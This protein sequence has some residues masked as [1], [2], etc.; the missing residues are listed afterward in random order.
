MEPQDFH[1]DLPEALIAQQPLAERT[2]SRLLCVDGD[3]CE[4]RRFSD[5]PDLLR[6]GDLL[7]MN[8]TRVIPARL[9]GRKSSGGKIELLL[10]RILEP[11]LALGDI[12]SRDCDPGQRPRPGFRTTSPRLATSCCATRHGAMAR[13]LGAL[14]FGTT[15]TS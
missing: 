10:E 7:V 3:A 4:D 5:L 13:A 15:A 11:D 14:A 12:A 8:D 2:A 1:F 9:F 6:P